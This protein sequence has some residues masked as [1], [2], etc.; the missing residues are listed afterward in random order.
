ML[1]PRDELDLAAEPVGRDPFGRFGREDLDHDVAVQPDVV[2]DEHA[3]HAAAAE[4]AVDA[5]GVAEGL[6]EGVGEGG[7]HGVQSVGRSTV[8]RMTPYA[9]AS[10][11][12][13]SRRSGGR[14]SDSAHHPL[15]IHRYHADVGRVH[16]VDRLVLH[17]VDDDV[18]LAGAAGGGSRCRRSPPRSSRNP[19]PGTRAIFSTML[20]VSPTCCRAISSGPRNIPPAPLPV[21]LEFG[22]ARAHRHDADGVEAHDALELQVARCRRTVPQLDGALRDGISDAP[23]LEHLRARREG[24]Q[25]IAAGLV[26][27]SHRDRPPDSHLGSSDRRAAEFR[28][29]FHSTWPNRRAARHSPRSSRPSQSPALDARPLPRTRDDGWRHRACHRPS[30][31]SARRHGLRARA[32]SSARC[33]SVRHTRGTSLRR[34]WSRTRCARDWLHAGWWGR[35]QSPATPSRS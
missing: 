27:P 18:R 23:N 8:W 15:P 30:F 22:V 5:V 29:R 1:E 4:L 10:S 14:S 9:T 3:R 13:V 34:W 21:P 20:L 11:R 31:E 7:G 19:A 35:R 28:G 17:A 24:A 33:R 26:G 2:R 25:R 32:P 6:L 12:S 16:V